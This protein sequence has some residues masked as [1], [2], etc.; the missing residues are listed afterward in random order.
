V[1]LGG[2]DVD[3][4]SAAERALRSVPSR[5]RVRAAIPA[6]LPRHMRFAVASFGGLISIVAF[7]LRAAGAWERGTASD[8]AIL[9]GA[10]GLAG[11][12]LAVFLRASDSEP[13]DSCS[14]REMQQRVATQVETMVRIV[15]RLRRAPE[16]VKSSEAMALR[17]AL[18]LASKPG[19]NRFL[20]LDLC[21]RVELVLARA[22]AARKGLMWSADRRLRI[23][24]R[25][26]LVDAAAHLADP[27]PANA[28]LAAIDDAWAPGHSTPS[29]ERAQR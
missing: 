26:L 25:G 20:P 21:G 5:G 6:R 24:V 12:S 2:L 11:A 3:V 29:G 18:S 15:K 17:A 23:E 7:G 1:V 28:D 13:H 9:F 10:I 16:T 27:S 22:L 19:P 4:E 14:S 8:S